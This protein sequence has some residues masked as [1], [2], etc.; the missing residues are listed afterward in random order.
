MITTSHRVVGTEYPMIPA[1]RSVKTVKKIINLP[2][3]MVLDIDRLAI[4]DY[5]KRSNFVETAIRIYKRDLSRLYSELTMA[6]QSSDMNLDEAL[7]RQHDVF[8]SYIQK[9]LKRYEQYESDDVTAIGL[10]LTDELLRN[11]DTF[12]DRDGPIKN[13]QIFARLAIARELEIYEIST[14]RFVIL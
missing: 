10:Y 7:K 3:P 4:G 1:S 5:G 14:I 6:A 12:I 13:L 8:M 11:I 9:D 2:D